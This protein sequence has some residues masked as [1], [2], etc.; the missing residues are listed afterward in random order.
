MKG[1]NIWN[2]FYADIMKIL[3]SDSYCENQVWA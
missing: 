3:C 2:L 1:E